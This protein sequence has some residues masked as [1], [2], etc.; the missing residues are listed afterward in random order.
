[1]VSREKVTGL[2]LGKI[3]RYL[4]QGCYPRLCCKAVMQNT[5]AFISMS[6]EN[7]GFVNNMMYFV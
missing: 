2:L 4:H 7:K 1:M 6:E 5:F 3:Y